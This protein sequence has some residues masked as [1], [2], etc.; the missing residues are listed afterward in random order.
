MAVS[1]FS[2]PHFPL[3]RSTPFLKSVAKSMMLKDRQIILKKS[4]LLSVRSSSESKVLFENRSEGIL[5]YRDDDGEI[6]CEG[7]DE[8]PRLQKQIPIISDH[9]RDEDIINLLH[10]KLLQI[11]NGVEFGNSDNNIIAVQEGLQ[12]E[13]L[14][15]D[16]AD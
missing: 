7:Y 3:Q 1:C 9:S 6:I 13:Q 12:V 4:P 2:S 16:S 8:G 10:Q 15:T 11:I 5:C 14:L